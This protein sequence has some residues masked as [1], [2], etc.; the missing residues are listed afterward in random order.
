MVK[1]WKYDIDR[2]VKYLS[3]IPG[4]K[5]KKGKTV[6]QQITAA[7]IEGKSDAPSLQFILDGNK[8][9][10]R[11]V[12]QVEVYRT[13]HS[14]HEIQ[15]ARSSNH[16][17]KFFITVDVSKPDKGGSIERLAGYTH[18]GMVDPNHHTSEGWYYP[19]LLELFNTIKKG[20]LKKSW[21]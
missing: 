10:K 8:F 3:I 6:K 16:E 18:A 19:E 13:T 4:N 7:Q 1:K 12:V 9:E 2:L 15:L 21:I 5:W 20:Y 14:G 11:N 17:T